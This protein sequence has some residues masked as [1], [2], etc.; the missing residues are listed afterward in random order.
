MNHQTTILRDILGVPVLAA[1]PDEAA[2]FVKSFSV[3]IGDAKIPA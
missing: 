1:T 2:A 3:A